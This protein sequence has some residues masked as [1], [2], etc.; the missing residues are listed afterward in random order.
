M[1]L[2][3]ISCARDLLYRLSNAGV[4]ITSRDKA[5]IICRLARIATSWSEAFDIYRT[6]LRF[7]TIASGSRTSRNLSDRDHV[8]ILTTF[9]GLTF[10]DSPSAPPEDLLSLLTDLPTTS[11]SVYTLVLNYFSKLTRPSYLGVQMT[12]ELLKRDATLEPDLALIN[13]LMNAYNR[14]DEPAMVL[15]IWD[16][17]SATRQEVDGTTMSVVFDTAGRHGLLALARKVVAERREGMGKG[18]WD[19][20]L[21]C[22]ARCGR[23]E[24]AIEVACGEMRR[25]L[26][27]QAIEQGDVEGEVGE[28]MV[29][30]MQAPVRDTSGK[31]VGRM[32]DVGDA[33]Q[34]RC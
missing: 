11:C 16:S 12:H 18:A 1:K 10:P 27:R 8:S 14:V 4:A 33:A 34:V 26:F 17:L 22:L 24:E 29:R 31:V 25:G 19:S 9:C 7:P 28:L 2:R 13:A 20:W 32:E 21:E 23:L 6:L 5:D 30:S 3:D 15:A